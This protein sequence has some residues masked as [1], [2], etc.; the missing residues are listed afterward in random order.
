MTFPS[1]DPRTWGRPAKA[2]AVLALLVIGY[3][4]VAGGVSTVWAKHIANKALRGIASVISDIDAAEEKNAAHEATIQ[5]L[6]QRAAELQKQIEELDAEQA[7]LTAELVKAHV[8]A[9]DANKARAA[10]VA[11]AAARPKVETLEQARDTLNRH[12][13]YKP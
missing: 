7:H 8:R 6:A 1:F 9:D 2:L 11:A 13:G 10:A 3:S 5:A 4:A 12:L